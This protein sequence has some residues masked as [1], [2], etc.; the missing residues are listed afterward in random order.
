MDLSVV[1]P[2]YNAAAS[3]TQ[4]LNALKRQDYPGDF[5]IIVVDDGST[6][7]TPAIVQGMAGV[8]YVRQDNAGPAAARNHGARLAAGGHL[9]FTDSDCSPRPDW[10]SRLM[11][12]FGP[13]DVAV[14]A[15]SYGIANPEHRLARCIHQEILLR[16]AHLMPQFP[17]SFGSYNFCVKKEVFDRVEGFYTGYREASGEDNDLAYKILKAG[18]RIH[19]ERKALVDHYHTT[20]VV[21]YLREQFR[22]GFWRARMYADHPHMAKGDDYTFWKDMLEVPWSAA[23][24]AGLFLAAAFNGTFAFKNILYFLWLPF[25]V[26]EAAFAFAFFAKKIDAI[27]FSFVMFFRAF[28]RTFGLSTGFFYFCMKKEQKK[29]K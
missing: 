5:E 19:F 13:S 20:R 23:C 1:I 24:I 4:T 9:A 16:H 6:D 29:F 18:G 15:G 17:K 11:A 22:H 7:A 14:V 21:K 27:F 28:A 2:A 3:I 10:L 12:G 8:R 26:F 25:L